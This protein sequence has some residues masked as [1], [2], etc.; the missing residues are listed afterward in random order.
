[1]KTLTKGYNLLDIH[2]AL[3]ILGGSFIAAAAAFVLHYSYVWS[4]LITLG[5]AVWVLSFT[6]KNFRSYWLAIFALTLPLEIKKL[7]VDSEYIR[8]VVRLNTLPVGALP[9][10]VIYLSDLPFAVLMVYWIFEIIYLK[11]KIFFP[12]ST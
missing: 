7:L 8:E 1:M 12:Q 9:G 4:G 6:A 5:L 11:R 10:P 3:A 2:W